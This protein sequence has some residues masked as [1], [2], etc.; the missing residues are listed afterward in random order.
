MLSGVNRPSLHSACVR[1]SFHFGH[2]K[3]VSGVNRPSLHSACVR[4]SFHFGHSKKVCS[5]VNTADDLRNRIIDGCETIRNTPGVF[6]R[7]RASMRRKA[8]ACIRV[9]GGHFQQLL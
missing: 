2:S 4:C 6:E 9:G 3:K 8:D 5:A 1:C 7:V